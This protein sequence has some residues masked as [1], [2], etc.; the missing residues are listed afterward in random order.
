MQPESIADWVFRSRRRVAI[1]YALQIPMTSAHLLRCTQ[2]IHGKMTRHDLSVH[3]RALKAS[4]LVRCLTPQSR[5]GRVHALS[6]T[7]RRLAKKLFGA[8]PAKHV[9]EVNWSDYSFVAR[10]RAR[11]SVV[12]RLAFNCRLGVRNAGTTISKLRKLLLTRHPMNIQTVWR[13]IVELSTQG[14]VDATRRERIR[15]YC[16][17]DSGKGVEQHLGKIDEQLKK[18]RLCVERRTNRAYD[19]HGLPRAGVV[20]G[21]FLPF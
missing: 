9:G 7:G 20:I 16:L 18:V 10:G 1:V 17:T 5:G 15:K 14:L 21:D 13:T 11:E 8:Q 12:R 2:T 3:I 6:E 19:R 4:R